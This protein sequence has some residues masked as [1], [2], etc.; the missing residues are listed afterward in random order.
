MSTALPTC[1]EILNSSIHGIGVFAK[2]TIPPGTC[3]GTYT[4]TRYTRE[5]FLQKYGAD[6]RFCYTT[7]FPWHP[8]VC[9]KES[10]H[11]MTYINE[12]D[13]PNVYFSR[14][15]LYTR[16]EIKAGEELLLQYPQHYNRSW[17]KKGWIAKTTLMDSE[18]SLLQS[19]SSS[20]SN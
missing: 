8:I 17:K 3:L 10:R 14:Y 11:F 7:S 9:A 15:K 4:G 2:E 13:S 1:L 18:T 6:Y 5:E 20:T 12:S 16:Q 19:T